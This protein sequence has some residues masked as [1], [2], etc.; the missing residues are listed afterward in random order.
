MKKYLKIFLASSL[1]CSPLF[2]SSSLNAAKYSISPQCRYGVICTKKKY[3]MKIYTSYAPEEEF[4]SLYKNLNLNWKS[5]TE[6]LID[7]LKK[8]PID[9]KYPFFFLITCDDSPLAIGIIQGDIC[10]RMII[11]SKPIGGINKKYIDEFIEENY[12][13]I[14][15]NPPPTEKPLQISKA[16]RLYIINKKSDQK[17]ILTQNVD[18][19]SI[20][21]KSKPG[22]Q[23]LK[24]EKEKNLYI[25][26]EKNSR[27]KPIENKY[28]SQISKYTTN[29]AYNELAFSTQNEKIISKNNNSKKYPV[30]SDMYNSFNY[31][32]T[33]KDSK[34]PYLIG[35]NNMINSRKKYNFNNL[36]LQ[37]TIENYNS[38]EDKYPNFNLEGNSTFNYKSSK[39][40]DN[41]YKSYPQ[42]Y[43]EKAPIPEPLVKKYS[44]KTSY[45]YP[46]NI[47]IGTL[48]AKS[49][50]ITTNKYKTVSIKEELLK[51][52]EYIKLCKKQ[53]NVMQ[54]LVDSK[55]SNRV[56]NNPGEYGL[57][58][59]NPGLVE[60]PEDYEMPEKYE[61]PDKIGS[62]NIKENN[63]GMRRKLYSQDENNPARD[64]NEKLRNYSIRKKI[65]FEGLS[66]A[67]TKSD[68]RQM[69]V[70]DYIRAQEGL[71]LL[72]YNL[73]TGKRIN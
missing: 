25:E 47:R 62:N 49:H 30:I 15:Q 9:R 13:F 61:I 18:K 60:V 66:S 16:E 69:H 11:K 43:P 42:E 45:K 20:V 35:N 8:H 56:K 32:N 10:L 2:G 41:T 44:K 34:N 53:E 63:I 22:W 72:N 21:D 31:R 51:D 7:E 1:L 71:A 5:Y 55:E 6:K 59:I 46:Q 28:N 26:S 52:E 38:N 23:E 14:L 73:K 36:D 58:Y 54:Q 24:N 68:E 65:N 70:S 67:L 4:A 64:Y 29:T 39:Y 50:R 33:V 12:Y 17:P 57:R 27:K 40:I 48:N 19:F 3:D 37:K